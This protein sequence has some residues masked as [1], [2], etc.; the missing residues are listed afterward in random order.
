MAGLGFALR[1]MLDRDDL[2]GVAAGYARC[3]VV[4]TGPWLFTVLCLAGICLLEPRMVFY[5]E[6]ASFQIILCYNFAF[7][8]VLSGPLL[9]LATRQLSDLIYLRRAEEAMGLLLGTLVLLCGTQAC[10]V[11][12]F[13]FGFAHLDLAT[14][15]FACIN[16]FLI[17]GIWTVQVF[18]PTL[19]DDRAAALSFAGG[20]ALA[21]AAA[22]AGGR[23]YSVAGMLAGFSAGLA[24]AFFALL[25]QIFAEYPRTCVRP[26]A[27]LGLWRRHWRLAAGGL[28]Y[29]AA[30]WVDKWVMWNSPE[31]VRQDCGLVSA[32]RYDSSMFLAYLTIVPAIALFVLHVET[33]FH[34]KYLAYLADIRGHARWDTIEKDREAILETVGAG[35]RQIVLWQGLVTVLAIL[36]APLLLPRLGMSSSEVGIFRLGA[37]GAFFH[38]LLLFLLILLSYFELH[39]ET[40]YV[41][42]FFLAA[43]AA[44]TQWSIAQGPAWYGYGYSLAATLAF[45][46]ACGLAFRLAP[47]LTYETFVR[48]NATLRG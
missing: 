5:E 11:V 2:L 3:V 16:F 35:A 17:S 6:R 24:L 28:A 15:L 9:A 40:L 1:K 14:R 19:R 46:L 8:L 31:A 36:V 38:A 48:R 37:L 41:Q 34:G 44:F 23:L 13:Y 26:W 21:F 29:N 20:L 4:S 47:T 45:A 30:I 33:R 25:A 22:A 39:R 32:P 7:S 10:V 12:P 18:L 42:L 27:V 43:N